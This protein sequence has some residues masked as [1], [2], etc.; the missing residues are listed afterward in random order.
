MSQIESLQTALFCCEN[1]ASR[2]YESLKKKRD[3]M[4]KFI[5]K[6]L[7]LDNKIYF[8]TFTF[9][10]EFLTENMFNRSQFVKWLNRDM[11]LKCRLYVDYGED[12]NRI[13]L[14]GFCSTQRIIKNGNKNKPYGNKEHCEL[15]KY[16]H[17]KFIRIKPNDKNLQKTFVKYTIDYSIKDNI[18]FKMICVNPKIMR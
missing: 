10:D 15:S 11:K 7:S 6:E 18:K 13:H 8:C 5:V 3:R 17:T 4:Y 14:H 12:Y 16:G 2:E 9:K 1:Y